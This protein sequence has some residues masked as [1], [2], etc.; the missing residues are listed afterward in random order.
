MDYNHPVV[1]SVLQPLI[2]AFALTGGINLAGR[3]RWGA[4]LASA[5][6]ATSL[7]IVILQLLG[8]PPWFPRTGMQKLS[9]LVFLGLLLG[10]GLETRL[11]NRIKVLMIGLIW[12]M[13]MQLWLAW[14]Q[15]RTPT[16]SLIVQ[17]AALYTLAALCFWRVMLLREQ[18]LEPVVMI[19]LAAIGLAGV[20]FISGSLS[21]AHLCAALAAAVGGLAL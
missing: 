2:V 19:L 15:L 21:I 3:S 10:I 16:P 4:C 9:Y 8:M 17:F 14:P 12:L 6:I 13:L 11:H 20:A 5:A 18:N 7:L 1:Q